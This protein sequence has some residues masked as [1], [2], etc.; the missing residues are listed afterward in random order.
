MLLLFDFL[1]FIKNCILVIH[2]ASFDISMMN[3]ELK[4]L[5]GSELKNKVFDTLIFS[6]EVYPGFPSYALQNLAKSFDITVCDAHRAED[7]SH[8]C[9]HLFFKA[10]KHFFEED[11]SMLE[12][13]RRQVNV[14]DYLIT[15]SPVFA[16]VAHEQSLF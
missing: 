7:D 1:A 14:D 11:A 15:P 9:M 16:K 13:Y 4:R 6:R 3:A 8:V 12:N 2:N 5:G 10:V